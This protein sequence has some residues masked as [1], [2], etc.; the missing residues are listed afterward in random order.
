MSKEEV[1]KELEEA[2]AKHY[3]PRM[4]NEPPRMVKRE[5]VFGETEVLILS[6]KYSVTAQFVGNCSLQLELLDQAE[7]SMVEKD[8]EA[9][10][11]CI[12]QKGRAWLLSIFDGWYGDDF[13]QLLE[14]YACGDMETIEQTLPE[15]LELC[16][17]G[18]DFDIVGSNLM[19]AIHYKDKEIFEQIIPQIEKFINGKA[20]KWERFAIAFLSA[21]VKGELDAAG[22]YLFD[23]CKSY[24][25][26]LIAGASKKFCI[27]AHGLYCM[28]MRY[29]SEEDFAKIEMP[30]IDNFDKEYA[31]WRILHKD[32]QPKAY[33]VFPENMK[34][35]NLAYELPIPKMTILRE[36][37]KWGHLI[38]NTKDMRNQFVQGLK[39]NDC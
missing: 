30:D 13:L 25:R 9:V 26:V 38:K 22:G 19:R 29:L 28:A 15:G 34:L 7:E 2:Y 32:I 3:V 17:Y 1:I 4:T 5:C 31:Q 35:V 8:W 37:G 18:Y 10:N 39:D 14:A 23:M 33:Y 24:K 27:Y 36:E 12:F 11:D 21:I 6:D 20:A 16:E